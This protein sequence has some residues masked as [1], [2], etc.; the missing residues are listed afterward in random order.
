MSVHPVTP[1]AEADLRRHLAA[2]GLRVGLVDY[3]GY[4][5]GA[6]EGVLDACADARP[7]A[8]LFDV[9]RSDDLPTIGRYIARRMPA[10]P[11]L[12]V[13]P[14]S[15]A[16]ALAAADDESRSEDAR[17]AASRLDASRPDGPTLALAGSLSPITRA[18]VEAATGYRRLAI[19]PARLLDDD[20]YAGTLRDQALALLAGDNVMLVTERPSGEPT[21]AA[22]VAV[23]TGALLRAVMAKAS[24]ARLVI[25]GGDTSSHAVA[26]L[27]VW[28]L[29]YRGPLTPG[30]PLCRVR[31]DD[32]RLDGLDIILKGG[33]MGSR[34][35]FEEARGAAGTF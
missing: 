27:D 3:R 34:E 19:D 14:S 18:Q 31:S 24:V 2:Q 33:Q 22:R 26:A 11:M 29:S 15:V 25:A 7:D 17:P 8:V 5:S 9:A 12:A 30:A 20:N 16:Q 21:A 10:G 13:G 1:M 32:A 6:A 23:A 35:F 28:G 4:E